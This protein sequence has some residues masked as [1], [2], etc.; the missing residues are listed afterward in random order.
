MQIIDTFQNRLKKAM[1]IRN[2]KQ[3]DLV[4]KTKLDKTLIN[5]YLA[6]VS[7][8]RQRKLTLLADALNVN[9]IWLMGYDVPMDREV[10][11]DI[12]GNPVVSIPLL[13]SVKAGYD[14][15]AQENWIGTVDVE[16]SLVG[17][18]KDFFALKVK[19]DSMAPVFLEEDIVIVKKQ[20]DCENNEFAI[21]IINGDEGTLKKIKKTDNGII[22]QPLNPAYGPVMYTKEEMETIPVLIAG[23]VKQLKREF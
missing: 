19:G 4:E 16:T 6:G 18:G 12:L 3:V 21:V 14:Y 2:I 22:L 20:N 7:N 10:K 15:L 1:E 23:I 13:G 5:K 9:E 11:T 8:A 17:D